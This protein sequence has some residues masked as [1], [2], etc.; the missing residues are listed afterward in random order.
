MDRDGH[1]KIFDRDGHQSVY[2]RADTFVY[3]ST[4]ILH[5]WEKGK[6]F[7]NYKSELKN[8]YGTA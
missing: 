2:S 3:S 8:K 6:Y 1:Q 5:K 4:K 7:L